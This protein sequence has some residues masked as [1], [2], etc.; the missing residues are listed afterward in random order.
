[1]RNSVIISLVSTVVAQANALLVAAGVVVRTCLPRTSMRE[2]HSGWYES[3][4]FHDFGSST[5][6][7]RSWPGL[8]KQPGR[9]ALA[10]CPAYATTAR[11]A[12]RG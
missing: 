6:A 10:L 1:M 4:S 9:Y 11:V 5:I 3:R 2:Q 8:N 12:P 7:Y